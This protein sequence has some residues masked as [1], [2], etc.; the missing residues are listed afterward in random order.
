MQRLNPYSNGSYF[1]TTKG[2]RNA[3]KRISLNPYSNGSYF[4]T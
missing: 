4:L 3:W 1:L 2:E